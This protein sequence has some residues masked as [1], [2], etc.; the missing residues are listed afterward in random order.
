MPLIILSF[1]AGILT[2]LAPCVFPL[3]PVIIGGSSGS[4]SKLR[5]LI[6]TTALGISIL[7]FTL[8]LKGTSLFIGAPESYLRIASGIILIGFGVVSI[9][10]GLWNT[11]STK[12]NLT[13]RS[14]KMLDKAADSKSIF[15]PVLLGFTLGPVFSSCSP[16]YGVLVATVLPQDFLTG[17]INIISY[18]LGLSLVMLTVGYLGQGIIS[19]LRFASNPN[20]IFKKILGLIFLIIGVAIVLGLDRTFE[21]WLLEGGYFDGISNWESDRLD[22]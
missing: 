2:V 1:I 18:I 13:G 12:L 10:P 22:E 17:V 14:D 7:I 3:L 20:G 8:L 21:T 19:K 9:Y 15:E 11:I 6:I 4:K 5:P 16:T